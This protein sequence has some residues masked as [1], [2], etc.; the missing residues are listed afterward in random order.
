MFTYS[1]SKLSGELFRLLKCRSISFILV[2]IFLQ[3]NNG[4]RR[5]FKG[6]ETAFTSLLEANEIEE[7]F[8][9]YTGNRKQAF[10]ECYFNKWFDLIVLGV[11]ISTFCDP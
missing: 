9:H 2:Y 4:K 7:V 1:R 5:S 3:I 8:E 6:Q 11:T 10:T